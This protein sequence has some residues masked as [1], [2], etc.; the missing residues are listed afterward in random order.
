MGADGR[1][2]RLSVDDWARAALDVIG[3]QGLAGVA[4]EPLAVRLG[5]TKGSFYWHFANRDALV[6]AALARWEREHTESVIEALG[7]PV[8]PATA[9]R[10]LFAS[11][12]AAADQLPARTEL[13]LLAAAD[14]PLVAPTVHRVVRRRVDYLRELFGGL[15]FDADEA[16]RRALLAYSAHVGHLQLL[17]RM[18]ELVPADRAD[19]SAYLDTVL[20]AITRRD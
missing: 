10:R 6:T 7:A 14:D 15:G 2:R 9:L 1:R 13:N 20:G 5:T 18:P 11:T 3:E 8:D 19:R 16:A 17:V 4:V 12:T